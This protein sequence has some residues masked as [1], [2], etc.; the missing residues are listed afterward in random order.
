MIL[1]A[2]Q[3]SDTK[4]IVCF[5]WVQTILMYEIGSVRKSLYDIAGD[6]T[7]Q[8]HVYFVLL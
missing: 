5:K 2:E 3:M 7:I 4:E 6:R 1:N 8:S